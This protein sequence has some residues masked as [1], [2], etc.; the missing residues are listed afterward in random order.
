MLD[1]AMKEILNSTRAQNYEAEVSEFECQ[2]CFNTLH[3]ANGVYCVNLYED[4]FVHDFDGITRS[5][6]HRVCDDCLR[7]MAKATTDDGAIAN[8]GVGLKCVDPNCPGVILYAHVSP[9]LLDDD[10]RKR[11]HKRLQQVAL[12]SL[13]GLESCKKC[14]FTMQIEVSK[15][16]MPSFQCPQSQ[17]KAQFCRTCNIDWKDHVNGSGHAK[18]CEDVMSPTDFKRIRLEE[19]LSEVVMRQC[20]CGKIFVKDGGCN[21]MHCSCG[22]TT[23]YICKQVVQGSNHMWQGRPCQTGENYQ[24]V[25]RIRLENVILEASRDE[26][27][28]PIANRLQ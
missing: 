4:Q 19:Q 12:S 18:K 28:R 14:Q 26:A 22:I 5:D 2:V 25:D 24:V 1:S 15:K 9:R 17:C 7:E 21:M 23:C 11:L 27:L 16:E 8:G 6:N 3:I 13:K 20:Q 10:V